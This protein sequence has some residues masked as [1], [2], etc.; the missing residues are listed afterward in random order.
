M[1]GNYADYIAQ[2]AA[3]LPGKTA[4]KDAATTLTYAQL[5]DLV[6]RSALELR[7][8]GA[9]PGEI[10]G[11][12]LPDTAQHVAILLAV[13]RLGAVILPMDHRWTPT[14]TARIA[15]QFGIARMLATPGR[16]PPPGVALIPLD[17]AWDQAVAA[18]PLDATGFPHDPTMPLLLS[19]SS[20]TTGTPKGPLSTHA[21]QI[22][23][24][25]AGAIIQD[26]VVFMAT[27]LY[28]GGGRGFS[29]AGLLRGATVILMPPPFKPEDLVAAMARHRATYGFLVPTQMR[30]LMQLP[31][32]GTPLL[33]TLRLLISSG[34][35]LHPEERAQ[36]MRRLTPHLVNL[37]SSTEG[38]S[39]AALRPEHPPEKARSVGRVFDHVTVQIV[40][41]HDQPVPPGTVGRI[42]QK[43]PTVPDGFFNN[44]EETAKHFKDGW[45]H[46]GDLGSLDAEGFLTLAGR[47]KEMIIRGG[48]NIYP[49]EIEEPLLALPQVH[50]CAAI[51]WPSPVMGEEIA[52]FVVPA[53]PVTEA[54]ILAECARVLSPYKV[55]KA[56]FFLD[57]LPKNAHGKV[58]RAALAR[59]L[60][61]NTSP[62]R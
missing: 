51:A 2:N 19:M 10:I 22:G 8:R 1:L 38:G 44:P 20:G 34:A 12:C 30:K 25:L 14:E 62:G 29:L 31:D 49:G 43:S 28:F 46:P 39:V 36:V 42:R 50:D 26:D 24:A 33:P 52:L 3:E 6:T 32:D 7:A 23:R 21:A 59:L 48:V 56:V 47:S 41:D 54:E 27:P 9:N 35:V 17:T 16:E 11:V 18:Q 58:T 15:A 5:D 13:A 40:D 57:D 37:Y 61:P 60:P 4:L 53:A 55:P 45:Y